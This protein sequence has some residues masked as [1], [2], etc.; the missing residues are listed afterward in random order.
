MVNF[1][2]NEILIYEINNILVE[3]AS[4]SCLDGRSE[5]EFNE[6]NVAANDLNS[7]A[8]VIT[9]AIHS[10]NEAGNLWHA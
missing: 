10:D 4:E 6:N 7:L 2:F 9:Q 3:M 1:L 5:N 8:S